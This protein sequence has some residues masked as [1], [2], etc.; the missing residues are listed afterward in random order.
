MTY[1]ISSK[2][3]IFKGAL[4]RFKWLSI[5]FGTALFL[6]MPL[7]IWMEIN[8]QLNFQGGNLGQVVNNGRLPQM[9][10]HPLEHLTNMAVSIIFGLILFYYL[11]NDK[12][13]TFFH[14]LPIKRW[15]MYTQNLL[16]GLTLIWL[17]IFINGLLVYGIFY[18]F[19]ITQIP[20][21][22]PYMY[23]TAIDMVKTNI[24]EMVPA[25]QVVGNWLYL[26]LLMTGL[27][28][29]FTVF[30]GMFTGNILLQG[31]LTII[32]LVL[33]LGIYVLVKFN[34]WKLLYGFSRD[35]N[36]INIEPLSPLVSYLDDSFNRFLFQETN[37]YAW[38]LIITLVLFG[39][40]PYLYKKRPAEAAGE[41]LAAE[42][43]RKLFKY[44]VT[45]CAAL[46][47]GSYFSSMN[48]NSMGALYLGYLVGAV[49][50]YIVADMVAYKSFHFYK[51]WKGMV[52]FCIVFVFIVA[53]IN[54]DLYGF[55]K[56]VPEQD[57]VKEVLLSN[58]NMD[59]AMNGG[60]LTGEEN[61]R[62]AREFHQQIIKME[63]QN[64]ADEMSQR[65]KN[66]AMY[67]RPTESIAVPV[68]QVSM[69]RQIN[70]NYILNNG[71]QVKRSYNIDIYRYRDFLKPILDTQEAKKVMHYRL[72]SLDVTKLDQI[73]INNHRLG[74]NIRIY[75][76]DEMN[77][78]IAALKKD[79]LNASYSALAE[80]K[81][82]S[83]A[84]IE[85]I[86]TVEKDQRVAI[87]NLEYLAEFKNIEAFLKEYGYVEDL[88]IN[89]ED[90]SK[91]AVRRAGTDKTTEIRRKEDIKVLLDWCTLDDSKSF[92][93]KQNE[94]EYGDSVVYYGKIEKNGNP[95]YIMF[96]I[97]P[98]SQQTVY[99][100]L[101]RG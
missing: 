25:W 18:Y 32:G 55:E 3:V 83:R 7:L 24:P 34:L 54:V 96:N 22:N 14:S 65:R 51:R 13:S 4:K 88:F 43:I 98:Y 2:W 31:A 86:S 72:F 1:G 9:I 59:G 41:T 80:G 85:F 36:D 66:D 40:S 23:N 71:A 15:V 95:M 50:G 76:Q 27:F 33:P 20:W 56:Y 100:I 17:P 89:P 21:Q 77:Q 69:M 74:K 6:E 84:G 42:W 39:F 67:K 5:L 30:V 58:L 64:K 93:N 49:L 37:W 53:S 26:S 48:E 87:Y 99:D 81:V 35:F 60:G 68:N 75:K 28:L 46:T 82:P 78:A 16:A 12:A 44:G 57:E 11:Q 101:K 73:N 97:P 38:Y 47:G 8:R 62:R 70:I 29:V 19:G 61:I 90:I 10:F 45:A 91:I 52:T 63:E 92:L 94:V 79:V